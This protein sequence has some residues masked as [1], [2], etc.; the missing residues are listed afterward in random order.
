MERSNSIS[1]RERYECWKIR[2][3]EKKVQYR[4]NSTV[5]ISPV[6]AGYVGG[7]GRRCI[8]PHIVPN[9]IG[10][11]DF[12]LETKSV[13]PTPNIG[14][15]GNMGYPPNIEASVWL[16]ER[17]FLPLA[18]EIPGLSLVLIGRNPAGAVRKLA[19]EP[20]VVVTGEIE[21]IWPYVNAVDV[22]VFP[23]WIGGGIKNKV[24]ET[25]YAGRPVVT[26]RI[27]NEGIDGISGAHLFL[28]E[29]ENDFLPTVKRLLLQ[30]EERGN[31]GRA[32]HEFVK[33]RFSWAGILPRFE[34]IILGS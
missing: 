1:F 22:F 14:F 24:L 12:S 17:I 3:W 29:G 27:G 33:E 30:P 18:R 26:T 19:E 23:L 16:Y 13:L 10:T 25:M 15:L 5:Y 21:N 7:T 11:E 28:C 4:V 2:Q 8:T 34:K 31:V 20:G 6:D 9:G 32:A